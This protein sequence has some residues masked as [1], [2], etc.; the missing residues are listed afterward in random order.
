MWTLKT[1]EDTWRQDWKDK[2]DQSKKST[3]CEGFIPHSI[4]KIEFLDHILRGST[5]YHSQD[6]M[7]H[8][9]FYKNDFIYAE[10]DLHLG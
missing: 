7:W 4:A 5:S 10:F 1:L 2:R 8:F 6:D 9:C 3:I